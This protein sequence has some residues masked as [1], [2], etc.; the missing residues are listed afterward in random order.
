MP[1]PHSQTRCSAGRRCPRRRRHCSSTGSR[2]RM[3]ARP[4]APQWLGTTPSHYA[5]THCPLAASPS[6]FNADEAAT[7]VDYVE[8]LLQFRRSRV[9]PEQIGVITPFAK[10]AA[11]PRTQPATPCRQP[12]Q[13]ATCAPRPATPRIR[14]VTT[15][16]RALRHAG[17]QDRD[18]ASRTWPHA[19]GRWRQGGRRRE[20]PGAGA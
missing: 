2:A 20:L 10:Q 19:G 8:Q 7:V 9:T 1:T 17:A 15:R 5:Y 4:G 11:T 16:D 3:S 13:A 12:A 6:W 18:A 14:P